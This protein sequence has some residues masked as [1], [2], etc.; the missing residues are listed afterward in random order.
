MIQNNADLLIA[1]NGTIDTVTVQGYFEGGSYALEQ[2][3]FENGETLNYD[4]VVNVIA[5][6][7]TPKVEEIAI[8]NNDVE[9]LIQAMAGFGNDS[10]MSLSKISEERQFDEQ[11]FVAQ[12]WVNPLK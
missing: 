11:S 8:V 5:G 10:G 6:T 7:Y 2:I 4:D 12:L 1:I 3:K 9:Q